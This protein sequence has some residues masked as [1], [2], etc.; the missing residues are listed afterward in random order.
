MPGYDLN[1]LGLKK[2][3]GKWEGL[4]N[5]MF[6]ASAKIGSYRW[7]MRRSKFDQHLLTMQLAFV[8]Y[9]SAFHDG[10]VGHVLLLRT[11]RSSAVPLHNFQI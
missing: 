3:H 4:H 2:R 8:S 9:R 11:T 7:A 1:P 5:A 6:T 10:N